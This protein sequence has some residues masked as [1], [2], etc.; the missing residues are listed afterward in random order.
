MGLR[1]LLPNAVLEMLCVHRC[2]KLRSSPRQDGFDTSPLCRMLSIL[3][4]RQPSSAR[5]SLPQQPFIMLGWSDKPP[6][7]L[8]PA[9]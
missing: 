4:R 7:A 3:E 9:A 8:Q 1:L 6:A 2:Y 5:G